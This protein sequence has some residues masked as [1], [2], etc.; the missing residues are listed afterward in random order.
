MTDLLHE[1]SM[2]PPEELDKVNLHGV[3]WFCEASELDQ[4][5]GNH[6]AVRL[7]L[8]VYMA[9]HAFRLTVGDSIEAINRR[10]EA[11]DGIQS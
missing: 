8:S 2:L 1:V 11:E 9:E 3:L 4:E 7:M 6:E 5:N 10:N